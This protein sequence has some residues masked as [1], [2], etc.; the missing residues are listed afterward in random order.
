MCL[1][2]DHQS[3]VVSCW[4]G[5]WF[6][7]HPSPDS[8]WRGD[9]SPDSQW[10]GDSSPDS[11]WRGDSSPDSCWSGQHPSPDSCWSGQHPSPDF[12][13]RRY[14]SP[15]F[16]WCSDS[17]PDFQWCSDSSANTE[18]AYLSTDYAF[19]ASSFAI[20]NQVSDPIA[21]GIPDAATR[22]ELQAAADRFS[23][24]G[25]RPRERDLQAIHA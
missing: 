3:S 25:H 7:R 21:Y 17:S 6:G 22:V 16:Q 18:P 13:W 1:D 23:W 8:Q 20:P 11:Q 24:P 10:R 14:S 2:A 5:P 4:F 15:D 12:Q 19:Y 9:S